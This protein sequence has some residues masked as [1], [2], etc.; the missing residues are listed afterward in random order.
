MIHMQGSAAVREIDTR[1]RVIDVG[2]EV[3]LQAEQALTSAFESAS[4]GAAAV[5]LNFAGMEYMNSAG[6]GLLVSLLIR[7]RRMG[8]RLAACCLNAHYREILHL[9]RLDEH[10]TV[11]ETEAQAL[12]ALE[13][14]SLRN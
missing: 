7:A 10:V 13:Q 8:V 11:F 6:I 12:A 5:I 14:A 1:L 3:N 2:G 4:T 9:T